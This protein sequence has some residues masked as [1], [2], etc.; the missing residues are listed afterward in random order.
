MVLVCVLGANYLQTAEHPL[1]EGLLLPHRHQNVVVD[2]GEV[3]GPRPKGA[4]SI[5]EE[6]DAEVLL[7]NALPPPTQT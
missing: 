3:A 2:L 7:G 4:H 6:V 1:E 5:R